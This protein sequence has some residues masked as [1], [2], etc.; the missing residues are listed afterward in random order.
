[1]GAREVALG[2]T[3][4]AQLMTFILLMQTAS[5]RLSHFAKTSIELQRA[6]AAAGRILQILSERPAITEAPDAVELETTQARVTFDHVSF[7]YVDE[8]VIRDLS[9]E[10]R[11]GEV[12]AVV[13]PSGAGK[14]TIANLVARLYDVGA[15]S[16]S[17]DGIDVR[18]IKLSSLAGIMGIVPQETVLFGA[19]AAEN[20]GYGRPSAS[21][22]E[23]I[24]AAKAANAHDFIAH[25]P[26]GYD[27]QVGERG[28]KLSGGQKQ[29]IAIARALLRDPALL[30]LD[31]ATSSLDTESEAAIHRALQTLIKGRTTI[32]IAHRLSTVRNAD[33]II[34]L[35]AGQVVEQG[36]HEDLMHRGEVYYRLYQTGSLS[37]ADIASEHPDAGGVS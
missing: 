29:R 19:T 12:V 16:V 18:R 3:S 8:P 32:I 30:I 15:G 10:V 17:I 37:S 26:Q 11:P 6:E 22:E 35:D 23:I 1:M 34:V 31:E 28:A 13:G 24:E 21:R 4:T 33:R 5:S 20:I 25:L 36:A 2:N 27:T 7:A 9:F 14:T